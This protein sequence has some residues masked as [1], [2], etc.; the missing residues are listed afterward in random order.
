MTR[1]AVSLFSGAGGFDIGADIAGWH[2]VWAN[3]MDKSACKTF[4]ANWPG[5]VHH[6]DLNVLA[7]TLCDQE[8]GK[9]GM[10]FGGPPCQG[11]SSAG[12]QDKDD[13]RSKMIFTFLDVVSDLES[14]YFL[15]ENVAALAKPKWKEVRD[16]FQ[17]YAENLGYDLIWKVIR[18]CDFGIPQERN[19]LFVFG[20]K[21][22]WSSLSKSSLDLALQE[23]HQK[24]P[25]LGALLRSLG[26]YG[27]IENPFSTGGAKI[28]IM[29]NP[30]KKRHSGRIFNG[31]G[32]SVDFEGLSRTIVAS[33]GNFT[34]IVDDGLLWGNATY[35]WVGNL[36]DI[37]HQKEI[38]SYP[39]MPEHIRRM[40]NI[41]AA[42]IQ[43]FPPDHIFCGSASAVTR[44][45]GN[46]VPAKL[47]EAMFKAFN[48]LIETHKI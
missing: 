36:Y 35:D 12:K 38:G 7:S 25:N 2:V 28:T 26:K 4:E 24:P 3:D 11:F 5:V 20:V 17:E 22:R 15:M 9:I 14:P 34:H 6:G 16:C 32:A 8:R 19:R 27:E 42:A 18:A 41:E 30:S 46:A 39:P 13:P 23:L 45:I 37:I 10:V 33:G 40:T 21:G 1:R 48:I 44:Q 29:K 43:T 47:G 31:G